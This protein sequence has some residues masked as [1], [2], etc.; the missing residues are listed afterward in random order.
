MNA[1]WFAQLATMAMADGPKGGPRFPPSPYYR[2]LGRLVQAMRPKL[3]VE[4]GVC[5]GG[6][7]YHMAQGC[8]DTVVVGVEHAVGSAFEQDNWAFIARTCPSRNEKFAVSP[9]WRYSTR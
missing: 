5:G 2:F 6:A 7:S 3:A 9:G 4:L 8:A 1:N